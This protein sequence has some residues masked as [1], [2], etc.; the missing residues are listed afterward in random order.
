MHLIQDRML[1]YQTKIKFDA[2]LPEHCLIIS[3]PSAFIL[4]LNQSFDNVIDHVANSSTDNDVVK[5]KVSITLEQSKEN[6]RLVIS[7]NGNRLL[8]AGLKQEDLIQLFLPFYTNAR[9]T[10]KKMGLGMYQMQN[11][12]TDLLKGKIEASLNEKG[13][14]VLTLSLNISTY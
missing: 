3:H 7:D 4:V 14:L 12:V 11:I 5:P 10:Q 9:G 2:S 13:G 6:L 1:T 8:Q